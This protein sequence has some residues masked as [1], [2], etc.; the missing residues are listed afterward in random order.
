MPL[1]CGPSV[2]GAGTW[3]WRMRRSKGPDGKTDR[4]GCCRAPPRREAPGALRRRS[5]SPR[6]PRLLLAGILAGALFGA[7][8]ALGTTANAV[9]S[10]G[11]EA[12]AETLLSFLRLASTGKRLR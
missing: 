2:L 1:V 9:E 5:N 12:E 3:G 8:H 7:L 10:V 6:G 4:A 11:P